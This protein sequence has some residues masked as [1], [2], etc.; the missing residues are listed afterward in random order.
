[1]KLAIAA[2]LAVVAAPAF[3]QSIV[4]LTADKML[5]PIDA[6]TGQAGRA[7]AV[8]GV[9]GAI[10]G[11]DFRPADGKLYAVAADGVIYT[12]DPDSGAATRTVK[13]NQPFAGA[14]KALVDFNPQAD[15]LR[16]IALDGT[17]LRVNLANGEAAVDGKLRYGDNDANKGKAPTVTVGAYTNSFAGARGTELFDLDTALDVLALQSPP[18]DGVL[19]TR[20]KLGLD[21]GPTAAMDIVSPSEGENVAYLASGRALYTIDIEKTGRARKVADLKGL[22]GQLIDIAVRPMKK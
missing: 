6:R 1:V 21:V 2:A 11:I 9:E 16:L 5:V 22:Q 18:N 17:S 10:V 3:A 8:S 13:I 14:P 20:G 7:V 15:R 12:V 19:Q 4:G